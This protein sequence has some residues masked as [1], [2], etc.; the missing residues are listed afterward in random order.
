MTSSVFI[1]YQ[2]PSSDANT[3]QGESPQ[4]SVSGGTIT[5]PPEMCFYGDPEP[6]EVDNEGY[7]A[8]YL[9][10]AC[11]WPNPLLGAFTICPQD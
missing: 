5:V 2:I 1:Q 7:P 3:L 4:L 6:S 8:H 9:G 11:L 10:C